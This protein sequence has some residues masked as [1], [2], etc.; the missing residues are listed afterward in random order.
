MGRMRFDVIQQTD[1]VRR[2]LIT[3]IAFE[4]VNLFFF[5]GLQMVQKM[6]IEAL[7]VW[8]G[9]C[10]RTDAAPEQSSAGETGRFDETAGGFVDFVLN[11]VVRR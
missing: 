5:D 6:N 3:M 4:A 11:F 8:L 1:N 10:A 9:I 2:T 7:G